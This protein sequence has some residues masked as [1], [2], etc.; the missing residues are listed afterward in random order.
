MKDKG[1]SLAALILSS[2]LFGIAMNMFLI[3]SEIVAGGFSG[4]AI[5]FSIL[6]EFPVGIT[7]IFLNIP[8]LA[9]NAKISGLPFIK[10]ALTL[11][12]KLGKCL[13]LVFI[14]TTFQNCFY[15]ISY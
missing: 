1:R 11:F 5:I 7:V 2:V 12:I 6:F 10:K 3:P 15:L 4:L 9:A 13:F 14:L 8:F